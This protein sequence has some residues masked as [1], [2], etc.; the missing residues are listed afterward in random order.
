MS[1]CTSPAR[2]AAGEGVGHLCADVHHL[3]RVEDD[4]PVELVAQR[5]APH[6]LHDDR[7]GAVLVGGVVDG[8]DGRV[9][10]AGRGD[11][12]GPEPGDEGVVAGQVG[13]EDLDRDVAPEHLVRGLPDLGHAAAGDAVLEPV[14]AADQLAREERARCRGTGQRRFGHGPQTVAGESVRLG[15]AEWRAGRRQVGGRVGGW[16]GAAPSHSAVR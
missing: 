14:A 10:Q 2:C 7:L 15:S 13:V 6:Q 11:G 9:V 16:V 8:D 12:L 5:G 4:P 3:A 1:R